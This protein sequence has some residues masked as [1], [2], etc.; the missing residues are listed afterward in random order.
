LT[1][2]VDSFT[3]TIIGLDPNS[4]ANAGFGLYAESGNGIVRTIEPVFGNYELTGSRKSI[5]LVKE[6]YKQSVSTQLRGYPTTRS[7]IYPGERVKYVKVPTT[8]YKYKVTTMAWSGS[9]S[10]G[11]EVVSVEALNGTQEFIKPNA[12]IFQKRRDM[13]VAALNS[14]EGISCNVPNDAF[15]VFPSCKGSFTTWIKASLIRSS[16]CFQMVPVI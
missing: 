7:L 4:L 11:N 5:F 1:G 10:V 6:E 9:V 15:Y 16:C 2:E 8:N 13:V 3:T 12:E 14:I